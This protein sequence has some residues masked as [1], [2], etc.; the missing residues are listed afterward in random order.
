MDIKTFENK[1]AMNTSALR[2]VKKLVQV[3]KAKYIEIGISTEFTI[4]FTLRYGKD[5]WTDDELVVRIESW[6]PN[7]RI[8]IYGYINKRG[9]SIMPLTSANINKIYSTGMKVYKEMK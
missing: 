9:Q 7:K 3:T 5:R 6:G 4:N 1:L 2:Q 8:E